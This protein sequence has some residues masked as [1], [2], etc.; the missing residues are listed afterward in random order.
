MEEWKLI[1]D[2][3]N[4]QVSNFGR[5][6][7]IKFNKLLNPCSD[8]YYMNVVLSNEGKQKTFRV[9]KLVAYYFC[10]NINNYICVDHKDLNKLN[11]HADN[12]RWVSF[13]V[14][15][16]N[17]PKRTVDKCSSSFKGVCKTKDGKYIAYININKKTKYLG[18]FKTELEAA[19]E[20]NKYAME[21]LGE[22]I[23]TNNIIPR[24]DIINNIVIAN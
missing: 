12:L 4:Y 9:H 23:I 17:Q 3:P 15:M 19:E 2:Y 22:Y 18:R 5:I 6:K 13:S 1:T 14:N 7:N 20:Y 10:E 24:L 16:Y 11:N 21:Y 8:G